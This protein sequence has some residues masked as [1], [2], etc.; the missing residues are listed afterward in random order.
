MAEL[1]GDLLDDLFNLDSRLWRS[2]APLL[3]RPGFLTA[4]YLA[5]KR[6]RYLPP[7]RMYLVFSLTFFALSSLFGGELRLAA[8]AD[9]IAPNQA[10][11]LAG[12]APATEVAVSDL[13]CAE[14][15]DAVPAQWRDEV[16]SA[17]ASIAQD[18]GGFGAAVRNNVPTMMFLLIPVVAAIMKLIYPLTGRRYIE[19]LVFCLHVHALFFLVLT[20]GFIL[21][22]L[23]VVA[24]SLLGPAEVIV[25]A[26]A[27]YLFG[28]VFLALLRVYRQ[29]KLV[30]LGKYALLGGGYGVTLLVSFLMTIAYTA[31]RF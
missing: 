21:E 31:V 19:H 22:K 6:A 17:C 7:F 5:G 11:E 1:A 15:A 29:S 3:F 16:S 12:G 26:G 14:L 25:I 18:S 24:P 10:A 13:G 9:E 8:D 2:V 27:L 20:L 30:T 23:V 28:Y 4:E